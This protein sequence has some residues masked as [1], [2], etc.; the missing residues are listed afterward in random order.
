MTFKIITYNIGHGMH[1]D[2]VIDFLHQE[3]PDI[4]CLQEV[5]TTGQSLMPKDINLF[6]QL[7][8]SLGLPAV[9]EEAFIC[10]N[11]TGEWNM[12]QATFAKSMTGHELINYEAGETIVED[13][14]KSRYRVNRNALVTTHLIDD[15]QFKIA[16]T[17]F[18]L[19]P[20]ASVTEQQKVAAHHLSDA[21]A[22]EPDIMLVGD[23]NTPSGNETYDIFTQ[24]FTDVTD[25]Q[26]PTLHPTIHRVG[27]KGHHVDYILYRGTRLRHCSAHIPVVD[28]SDHLPIIAEFEI[29]DS[30]SSPE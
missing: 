7:Q 23:M 30:G 1:I 24:G 25:G 22:G 4:I 21:L 26:L 18:T 3:E 8:D 6:D 14:N 15:Y 20:E 9:F 10:R 11:D 13:I 16:N 27:F 28:A 29:L 17:H 12:G 5:G 19:T 2:R